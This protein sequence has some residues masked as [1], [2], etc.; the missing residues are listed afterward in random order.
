MNSFYYVHT[1]YPIPHQYLVVQE[2][3]DLPALLTN[4]HGHQF[5]D[6]KCLHRVLWYKGYDGV[7]QEYEEGFV[8][9]LPVVDIVNMYEIYEKSELSNSLPPGFF[10]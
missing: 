5:P 2:C 3:S 9:A 6:E 10:P 8:L 1:V 7:W 4:F